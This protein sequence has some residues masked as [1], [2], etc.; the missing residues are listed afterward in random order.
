MRI[1]IVNPNTTSEMTASIGEAARRY[2]RPDTEIVALNPDRGPVSIEGYFDE[3][4]AAEAT[5]E[6]LAE[7]GGR[8]DAYVISCFGDPGLFAAR[9]I[10]DA[11]VI[12]IAEAAMLTA[13]MLGYRFSIL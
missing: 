12:G 3:V 11:P 6:L 7:H 8:F 10:L 4:V 9:E 13:C 1:L 5:V 2:A